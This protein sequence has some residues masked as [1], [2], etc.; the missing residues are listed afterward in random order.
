MSM[1]RKD[2]ESIATVLRLNRE[3]DDPEGHGQLINQAID[4]IATMLSQY[5]TH[6]NP[7]FDHNRFIEATKWRD[8]R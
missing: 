7:R 8:T 5:F 1:S 3:P 2:F 6:M 4:D